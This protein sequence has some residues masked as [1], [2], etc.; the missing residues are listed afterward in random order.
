MDGLKVRWTW[1]SFA[2]SYERS[3]DGIVHEDSL[4]GPITT[5]NVVVMT[6]AYRPSPADARSP[7]AQTIGTGDAMVLTGGVVERGTWTRADR[8]SPVVLTSESGDPV[9]LTPGRTWVELAQDGSFA[10]DN[11]S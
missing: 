3:T 6:V 7:E 11:G 2:G 9:L 4:S 1:D 8:L 10:T 5:E